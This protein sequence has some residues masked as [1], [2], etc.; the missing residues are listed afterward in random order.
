MSGCYEHRFELLCS[1]KG[2]EFLT[3]W[4]TANFSRKISTTESIDWL[5]FVGS[6]VLW[7]L[8]YMERNKS[9][10]RYSCM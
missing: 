3:S 6:L 4:A 2:G 5:L 9:D 7:L 8:E 1:I 10:I